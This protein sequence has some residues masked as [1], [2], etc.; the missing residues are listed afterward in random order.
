QKLPPLLHFGIVK[1]FVEPVPEGR[2]RFPV[3]FEGFVVR[4][5]QPVR[6]GQQRLQA[7][8]QGTGGA[9]IHRF[10]F[11]SSG[12]VPSRRAISWLTLRCTRSLAIP[13][14]GTVIP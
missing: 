7:L 12:A 6:F 9:V 2:A 8:A 5:A 1:E 4:R 3:L 13:T 11:L 10:F 14:A